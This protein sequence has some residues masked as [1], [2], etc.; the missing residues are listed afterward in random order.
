MTKKE[1][2]I[3][4]NIFGIRYNEDAQIDEYKRALKSLFWHLDQYS[5]KDQVR[6]VLGGCL[7]SD[8]CINELLEFFPGRLQAFSFAD[9]HTCQIVTNKVA[10]ECEKRYK[11]EY[12]GY[13]YLSSGLYFPKIEDWKLFERVEEHM[14]DLSKTGI[15]Q[16]QVNNDNGY[17]FLGFGPFDWIRQI[18][19]SKDYKIGL[20]NCA[21]FHAAVIHRSIR[22]YY[23]VPITD[24]HGMCGMESVLSYLSA[25]LRRD[26]ILMGD[27]TLHHARNSDS[28]G[29][30]N[31]RGHA[32]IPCQT[33]MFGRDKHDIARDDL[34]KEVGIGYYP[35]R[36]SNNEPDWNGTILE[37]N[38][39]KYDENIHALHP[40]NKEVAKKYFFSSREE[41]D[42]DKIIF[43]VIE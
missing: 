40:R 1:L 24:V 7:V 39:E 28:G 8:R 9:R 41:L 22:D 34:A 29:A 42:Y 35:G 17:H 30:M 3:I 14:N 4:Y 16:L 38:L 31:L 20:G 19:F 37:H 21:N 6:V 13:F 10:L 33:Q 11:E 2:L 15:L 12:R 5:K 25:A 27:S 23:G 18:D 32:A 26:Y 36:Q 43:E